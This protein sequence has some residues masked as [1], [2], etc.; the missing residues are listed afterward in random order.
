MRAVTEFSVD[1]FQPDVIDV[2]ED[3]LI[4][5]TD[6]RIF[7]IASALKAGYTV[8]KLHDLTKIDK[9]DNLCTVLN[10]SHAYRWFLNKLKNISDMERVI[11]QYSAT[12]MPN[13]SLIYAKQIGF[14]DK[15]IARCM[16]NFH[17]LLFS[18]F[19]TYCFRKYRACRARVQEGAE[20]SACCEAHRYRCW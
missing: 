8:D 4:H 11:A 6:K 9:Y 18:A 17:W 13:D 12:T 3:E 19:V 7:V 16:G 14:S 2:N 5:P 1:G 10:Y 20:H 15:Q